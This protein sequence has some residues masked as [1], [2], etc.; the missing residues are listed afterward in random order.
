MPSVGW[1]AFPTCMLIMPLQSVFIGGKWISSFKR[2]KPENYLWRRLEELL[3]RVGLAR[4][5]IL[6][7]RVWELKRSH[8][9]RPGGAA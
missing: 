8:P 3:A 7:S 2:G 6:I 9:I 5:L 4:G 1:I